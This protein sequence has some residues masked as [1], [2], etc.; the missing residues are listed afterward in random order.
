MI[1][2]FIPLRSGSKSIPLKNIKVI[3]GKPL[4]QWVVDAANHSHYIDKCIISIDSDEVANSI[5]GA[6][7]FWRSQ[8]TATD[9]ASSE[10]ALIEFCKELDS[11]DII[12]FIQATTPTLITEEINLG[13]EMILSNEYDSVLSVVRQKRFIWNDN[14]QATYDLQNRPRRQDWNGYLVEN[15]A[16]YISKVKS[17]LQSQ[18]RI[19]GRIGMVECS[20]ESYYEIDELEDW[21]IVEEILKMKFNKENP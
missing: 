14:G 19:S 9:E 5:I 8:E 4:A 2:A 12:V 17:I 10:S 21:I 18:C 1:I 11:D 13:I 15:G 20:G 3:A 6:D 16:F 7:I